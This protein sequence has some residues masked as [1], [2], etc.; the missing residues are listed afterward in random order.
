METK[1]DVLVLKSDNGTEYVNK[2]MNELLRKHGIRHE[3][4]APYV[5]QQNG[6]AERSIRTINDHAR[7]LRLAA[8]LPYCLW[9]EMANTAVYLLNRVADKEGITPY[10][11]WFGHKPSI[12]HL[13]VIGSKGYSLIKTSKRKFDSKTKT[14]FL[15][16]YGEATNQ[17]RVYV[18]SLNCVQ[19]VCSVVFEEKLNSYSRIV[20]PNIDEPDVNLNINDNKDE[21][22]DDDENYE[23]PK[24]DDDEEPVVRKQGRPL[25]SKNKTYEANVERLNSLRPRRNNVICLSAKEEPATYEEARNCNDSDLWSKAMDCEIAGIESNNTWTLVDRPDHKTIGLKR[26]NRIKDD[27]VYKAKLVALNNQQ[28]KS[29]TYVLVVREDSIRYRS[30]H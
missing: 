29:S 3:T 11:K 1:N 14:V 21:R 2:Q 20:Y 7:T 23:E 18:P 22:I 24:T 15:I 28:K 10:T 5:H 12:S 6:M 4:S 13:R 27:G 9:D 30:N 26:V 17:Y 8:K 19:I 16:G 25:G